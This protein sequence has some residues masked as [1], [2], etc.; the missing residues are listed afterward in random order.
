M[1]ASVT[2]V[3]D[4]N[5]EDWQEEHPTAGDKGAWNAALAAAHRIISDMAFAQWR[6]MADADC[7]CKHQLAAQRHAAM[8]ACRSGGR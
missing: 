8:L 2:Q 6:E 7:N 4:M 3:N 5:F 1:A